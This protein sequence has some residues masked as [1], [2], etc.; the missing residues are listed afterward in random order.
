MKR[1]LLRIATGAI[2]LVCFSL[3]S[4]WIHSR[5]KADVLIL[6]STNMF[7]HIRS[8]G[9]QLFLEFTSCDKP[10]GMSSGWYTLENSNYWAASKA[11]ALESGSK[12]KGS[13]LFGFGVYQ[14]SISPIA[15]PRYFTDHEGDCHA[16]LVS[17]LDIGIVLSRIVSLP[18]STSRAAIMAQRFS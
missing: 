17:N 10:I 12:F 1:A 5:G 15:P 11:N 3:S 13:W 2:L 6:S 16:P 14:T 9:G 18:L 8:S 7:G 4:L